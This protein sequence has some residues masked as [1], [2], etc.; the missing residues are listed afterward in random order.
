L[1]LCV[2][3]RAF[4]SALTWVMALSFATLAVAQD[5]SF[6]TARALWNR[7]AVETYEYGY[8]KY[9]ECHPETPPETIVTVRNR[10][11]VAVRHR[12]AGYATEV[13]AEVRNLEF[14]WTIDGLFELL[15]TAVRRGAQVR[16]AFDATLGHPT[17][18]WIDYDRD[19]IGDE[20]DLRI[21]RIDPLDP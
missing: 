14:Y 18:I 2:D 15:E 11:V 3:S 12:S 20:L 13:A 9:C 16:S 10:E 4:F 17:S 8:Q 7:T 21:T 1:Q 5:D 19:F 6:E